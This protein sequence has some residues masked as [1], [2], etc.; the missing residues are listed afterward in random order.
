M[1]K[2]GGE[3]IKVLVLNRRGN[4]VSAPSGCASRRRPPDMESS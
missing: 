3:R 1:G 2:Q 4:G